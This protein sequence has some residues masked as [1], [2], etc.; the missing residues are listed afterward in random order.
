M[1][2]L[3]APED[4]AT[5]ASSLAKLRAVLFDG[6]TTTVTNS[7]GNGNNNGPTTVTLPSV[8]QQMRQ[9]SAG[10]VN[11]VPAA[12]S[13]DATSNNNNGDTG[14]LTLLVPSVSDSGDRGAWVEAAA[15]LVVQQHFGG[16]VTA[17]HSGQRYTGQLRQVANHVVVVLP[18]DF[19][20][21]IAGEQPFLAKGEID[22]VLSVYAVTYATSLS[23]YLHELGHNLGLRHAGGRAGHAD[24]YGDSSGYMGHSVSTAW[25]PRKC[26]NAAQHWQ[27]GWYGDTA[28]R[29]SLSD[30]TATT[31]TA[32]PL[33]VTVVA[34][35][36][37]DKISGGGGG[38]VTAVLVQLDADTYLQ[39][40]R[41][42]DYNAGTELA[43]DQIAIV[44][45]LG[46]ITAFQG[47]YAAGGVYTTASGSGVVVRVCAIHIDSD[48]SR[49]DT[50]VIV[51]DRAGGSGG[52]AA[53]C[54]GDASA[55][56]APPDGNSSGGSSSSSVNTNTTETVGVATP[57]KNK[58]SA[59]PTTAPP[60][61]TAAP[62][63]VPTTT[64]TS[65]PTAA[66]PPPLP[67]AVPQSAPI[68]TAIA[69]PP[70]AAPTDA[71]L[72][73]PPPAALP[74]PATTNTTA[75]PSAVPSPRTRAPRSPGVPVT[76]TPAPVGAGTNG[77]RGKK[78]FTPTLTPTRTA[79][80]AS[81]SRNPPV[82]PFASTPAPSIS[83]PTAMALPTNVVVTTAGNKKGP[84]PVISS[85]SAVGGVVAGC[86]IF[87]LLLLLVVRRRR[88]GSRSSDKFWRRLHNN[89]LNYNNNNTAG[90]D[91]EGHDDVTEMSPSVAGLRSSTTRTD[92]EISSNGPAAS[93]GGASCLHLR[94]T[95]ATTNVA[96]V[97]A[98]SPWTA[99]LA[100]DI[101][102]D[103]SDNS[104]LS[105]V[106][107][108]E[109][110]KERVR[111]ILRRCSIGDEDFAR[112]LPLDETDEQ[113]QSV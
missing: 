84:G 17:L 70:T 49:I 6:S 26:Y 92:R 12:T 27:L 42:K 72:D 23:A 74:A 97:A 48:E 8:Q 111:E 62:E 64:I 99:Y 105:A 3:S 58:P 29:L 19:V 73:T 1:R 78:S 77:A 38:T 107:E 39:F 60:P 79:A 43:R 28:Q 50:A 41:A 93:C 67:T 2:I 86:A 88:N 47:G 51:V 91:G 37:H 21:S 101:D 89:N 66:T 52:G 81:S 14:I 109:I 112:H 13:S 98:T 15:Q 106:L 102:D 110:Q 16:T 100:D 85:G 95:K 83:K 32:F 35:V 82:A 7:N 65:I 55:P 71:V 63:L 11:F 5:L 59:L 113:F 20:S 96:P 75:S 68:D 54:G 18:A 25:T 24:E 4:A 33:K 30:G 90:R 45:D 34:F 40:N 10:R 9:C 76:T 104:D 46:D 103:A 61:P 31:A 108:R 57:Y 36:D 69:T 94:P 44:R 87:L 22:N 80:T 56:L 53:L